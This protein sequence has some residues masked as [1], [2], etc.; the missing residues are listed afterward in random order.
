MAS[1]RI[2]KNG[3]FSTNSGYVTKFTFSCWVKRNGADLGTYSGL[4]A[5]SRDD[6]WVNSRFKLHFRDSDRLGWE[7]KDSGGSD[8]N[9]FETNIYFAVNSNIISNF[10]KFSFKISNF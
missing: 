10:I 1:T 4:F 6:N 9:S 2:Q 3:S 8:D 5:S 7:M